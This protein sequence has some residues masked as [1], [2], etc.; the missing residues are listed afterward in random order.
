MR[1][2]GS[3]H[4]LYL[5]MSNS[6]HAHRQDGRLEFLVKKSPSSEW[7]WKARAGQDVQLTSALGK[8]FQFKELEDKANSILLLATGTGIAPI[9]A[10]IDEFAYRWRAQGKTIRLYV[11]AESVEELPLKDHIRAWR[12]AGVSVTPCLSRSVD[13]LDGVYFGHVQNAAAKD[14]AQG[15]TKAERSV[16]LMCGAKRMLEDARK[17]LGELGVPTVN[18]VTNF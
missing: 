2:F 16:V 8:G 15:V 3:D 1:P 10:A 11:G 6:P 5:A 12:S 4:P 14:F 13:G 7:L 18:F 9:N 17:E